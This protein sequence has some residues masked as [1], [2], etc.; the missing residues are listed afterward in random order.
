[1]GPP[2]YDVLREHYAQLSN[3]KLL[4]LSVYEAGQLTP[5][6]RDVLREQIRLRGLDDRLNVA[7]EAQERS[8][9]A[10]E[11]ESLV[12]RFR[13]LPCPICESVAQPLNAFPIATARGVVIF[14]DYDVETVIACPHC[15]V[16]AAKRASRI[17]LCLGWWAIP[18]GPFR[19]IHAVANNWRAKDAPRDLEPTEELYDYVERNRG[20]VICLLASR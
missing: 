20:E 11:L 19:T 4:Q 18:L 1:M 8:L 3:E 17:T 14:V 16:A 15:I 7:I 10:V 13:A 12:E 6:A 5:E 9:T 2:D